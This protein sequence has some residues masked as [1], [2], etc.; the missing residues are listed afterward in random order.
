MAQRRR[1][2]I[3][4]IS[5]CTSSPSRATLKIT[6]ISV[7]WAGNSFPIP[8]I[9]HQRRDHLIPSSHDSDLSHGSP[10]RRVMA[11]WEDLEGWTTAFLT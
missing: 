9:T 6:F 2:G 1:F 3:P 11:G 7:L 5:Y 10:S 4:I 8:L